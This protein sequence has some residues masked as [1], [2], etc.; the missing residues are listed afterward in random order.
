[1][2]KK[3]SAKSK[4]DNTAKRPPDPFVPFDQA[5][6]QARALLSWGRD[7]N[8]DEVVFKIIPKIEGTVVGMQEVDGG[9]RPVTFPVVDNSG[10][11]QL[12][13][14][15][16]KVMTEYVD[17]EK[18]TDRMIAHCLKKRIEKTFRVS[19]TKTYINSI[20]KN[21][22][23]FMP[24]TEIMAA[25][26]SADLDQYL[27]V[28]EPRGCVEVAGFNSAEAMIDKEDGR[29]WFPG[30][31]V[32]MSGKLLV[33][34]CCVTRDCD[35]RLLGPNWTAYI[36]EKQKRENTDE[37]AEWLHDIVDTPA[38]SALATLRSL[39][40]LAGK[41]LDNPTAVWMRLCDAYGM[42]TNF[43]DAVARNLPEQMREGRID[44]FRFM[45][46][47]SFQARNF[48]TRNTIYQ[49]LGA[50]VTDLATDK[51]RCKT[52]GQVIIQPV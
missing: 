11:S 14:F 22:G 43:A 33:T 17:N 25:M 46:W 52:C 10:L 27:P 51:S 9:S 15:S 23:P 3:K 34:P 37:L 7:H 18:L 12:L 41:T 8:V 29:E 19:G 39:F 32:E 24:A 5:M 31:I 20:R 49:R 4:K 40:A 1:M 42:P 50:F 35:M 26:N 21:K 38:T 30:V 6:K 44:A 36:L 47:A 16:S 28:R 48:K 2:A 45:T 13:G